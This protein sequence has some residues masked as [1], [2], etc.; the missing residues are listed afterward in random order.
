MMLQ[1][2]QKNIFNLFNTERPGGTLPLVGPPAIIYE[3]THDKLFDL[4]DP[5]GK[6]QPICIVLVGKG[7][8][9]Y[10]NEKQLKLRVINYEAF[11]N[12]FTL[13]KIDKKGRSRVDFIVYDTNVTRS[14]FILNELTTGT[15]QNKRGKARLQLQNTLHDLMKD[16][17]TKAYISS[18]NNKQCILSCRK[19]PDP[20][21][22]FDMTAGFNMAIQ[23]IPKNS[24]FSAKPIEKLGFECIENDHVLI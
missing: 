5:K 9:T 24:I 6:V 3:D 12:L 7:Q 11:V 22:P 18:F 1:L 21:S 16:A 23:I 13:A 20:I 4:N 2:L 14:C 15:F 10:H 17:D 19:E 8:S